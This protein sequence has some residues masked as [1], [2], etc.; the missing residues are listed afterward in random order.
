MTRKWQIV[1]YIMI[2]QLN[3]PIEVKTTLGTGWALF[4]IDYGLNINTIWVV[5]LDDT[6]IVK[7]LD[8]NDIFVTENAMLHQKKV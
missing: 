7:H 1:N 3:P 8:A 2:L 4:I 5:R 6:G